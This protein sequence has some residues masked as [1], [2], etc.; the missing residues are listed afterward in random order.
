MKDFKKLLKNNKRA[1][2]VFICCM[3]LTIGVFT[4]KLVFFPN[5]GKAIYGDRL[6]GIEKVRIRDSKLEQIK[7]TLEEQEEVDSVS[8]NV[9]GRI[10]NVMITVKKDTSVD[11]AKTFTDKIDEALD[12]D[13][14]DYFDVQ[15]FITKNDEDEKFPIIGYRHQNNDHY[16]W[17]K[18]R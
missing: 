5:N 7:S 6:D 17:T 9:S 1:V 15:I 12:E 4:V 13:Q 11:T 8:T 10:L 18:D 16:S 2:I 3:I 14:K